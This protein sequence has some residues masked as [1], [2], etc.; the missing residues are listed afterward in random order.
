ML[1][2]N[3]SSSVTSS[4]RR[5][6]RVRAGIDLGVENRPLDQVN[7]DIPH[8]L[9]FTAKDNI[10]VTKTPAPYYENVLQ[11]VYKYQELWED[12][13]ST[14]EVRFLSDEECVKMIGQVEPRLVP[15]FETENS[16]AF[17]ADICRVAALQL[18]GGYYFDIDM[19][20]LEAYEPPPGKLFATSRC[21]LKYDPQTHV[22]NP[23]YERLKGEGF[24]SQCG[25]FQSLLASSPGHPIMKISLDLMLQDY[26]AENHSPMLGVVM[27]HKA[28]YKLTDQD[29]EGVHLL[30]TKR[31]DTI[32]PYKLYPDHPRQLGTSMGCNWVVDDPY[33]NNGEG[34]I[35]FW[36]RFAS[37]RGGSQGACR[38]QSPIPQ[39]LHFAHAHNPNQISESITELYQE[40][41]KH[42]AYNDGEEHAAA[43][44][45]TEVFNTATNLVGQESCV[46]ELE[47]AQQSLPHHEGLTDMESVV[48]Y[49]NEPFSPEQI[50][51]KNDI[52]ALL[53][54][55]NE[56]G[57]YYGSPIEEVKEP[58]YPLKMDTDFMAMVSGEHKSF[59]SGFLASTQGHPIIKETLKQIALLLAR[60]KAEGKQPEFRVSDTMTSAY[61]RV[62]GNVELLKFE[63]LEGSSKA[64]VKSSLGQ[65][66]LFT[67][68]GSHEGCSKLPQAS[69][70]TPVV[71]AVPV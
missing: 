50:E 46:K 68:D 71:S 41:G 5:S 59:H 27:M 49:V 35:Y 36:A 45:W 32:P 11:T 67:H 24:V 56:G 23:N 57:F 15:Y 9:W 14:T 30:D 66:H 10:L 65:G 13:G 19:E 18:H 4:V 20:T 61:F 53:T 58:V 55:Y 64:I 39:T 51:R 33:Y 60:D 31:L 22:E 16:G 38:L 47:L 3:L 48:E 42:W 62:G 37:P 7:K 8:I 69:K 12:D 54:L 17:K 44:P 2:D 34:K 43:I 1:F 40:H 21:S 52:C 25:F 28:Y 26:I 29:K 6:L 70:D 63:C